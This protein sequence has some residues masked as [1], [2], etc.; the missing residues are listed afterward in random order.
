MTTFHLGNIGETQIMDVY[1]VA[2]VEQASNAICYVVAGSP[3]EAITLVRAYDSKEDGLFE[4]EPGLVAIQHKRFHCVLTVFKLL[5]ENLMW[6]ECPGCGARISGLGEDTDCHHHEDWDLDD[7]IAH[8]DEDWFPYVDPNNAVWC[9]KDCANDPSHAGLHTE[10][11]TKP[12]D[13]LFLYNDD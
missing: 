1:S 6:T 13:H 7:K 11:I 3:E 12:L 5:E 4:D 9:C 10:D 8:P 2:D